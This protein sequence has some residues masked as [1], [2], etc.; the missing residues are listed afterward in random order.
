M[1]RCSCNEGLIMHACVSSM[2]YRIIARQWLSV[3]SVQQWGVV[4]FA[5]CMAW[6]ECS[7]NDEWVTAL[8]TGEA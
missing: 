3:G 6:F 7:D 2:C 8:M 5:C 4:Y 1:L